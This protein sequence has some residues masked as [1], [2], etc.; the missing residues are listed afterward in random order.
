MISA[1]YNALKKLAGNVDV[2]L[3]NLSRGVEQM[4]SLRFDPISPSVIL[5][6]RKPD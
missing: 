3:I 2:L 4:E 6:V 1:T 5:N